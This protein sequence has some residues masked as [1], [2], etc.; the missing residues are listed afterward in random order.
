MLLKNGF[1]F[2]C[3]L[4]RRN[5]VKPDQQ[6]VKQLIG[7]KPGRASRLRRGQVITKAKLAKELTYNDFIANLHQWHHHLNKG[8]A[9]IS[10]QGRHLIRVQI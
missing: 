6:P 3:S 9:T 1:P 2:L 5:F 10:I 8:Q 4:K 7:L